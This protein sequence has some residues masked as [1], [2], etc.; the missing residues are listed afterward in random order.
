MIPTF[1]F[2]IHVE[3]TSWLISLIG[4]SGDCRQ[5]EKYPDF[6]HKKTQ[7]ALWLENQRNPPWVVVEDLKPPQLT[8]EFHL[9][10]YR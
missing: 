6:K 9:P 5:I 10:S 8:P 3:N 4:I 7:E 1:V 2:G